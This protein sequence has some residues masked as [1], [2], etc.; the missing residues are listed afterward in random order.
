MTDT[1]TEAKQRL[2]E[3]L[4]YRYREIVEESDIAPEVADER[5][6]YLEKTKKNLDRL[7]F[8][9]NQQLPPA[10]VIPR[11][12][13][14]GEEIAPQI[15]PDSPRTEKRNGKISV[16]KYESKS[17]TPVRLSVHPRSVRVMR[18]RRYPLWVTE[19][20]K[21]ADSLVS[22]KA[23]A[24]ALQGVTCWNVPQDWEDVKLHGRDVIL[25]FDADQM[26][27]P[28]VQKELLKLS[29][30][31]RERGAKVRYLRWPERYKGTKTGVDD[32]LATGE[33]TIDELLR[34][35]DDAPDEEAIEVGT[36]LSEIEPERVEWLWPRRIPKGK[37][38]IIDGD[39][40]NG[41]SVLSTDLV[42]RITAGKP[43]PDGTPT[44][45]AG[46]I[47]LSAED[48]A[49]DTIRPRLDAAGGNPQKVLLLGVIPE[50]NDKERLFQIPQDLHILE[51]AIRQTGASIVVI[52]PLMAFLSSEVSS[53]SDQD[54]RR[55]LAPLA[56]LAERTG[57]AIVIIRHLNKS[58]GGNT[59]YRG[60]G[61]IGIIGAARSGLVVGKHPEDDSIRVLA[62]QKNNLSLPPDSLAYRIEE[63]ENGSARISYLGR[64]ETN[65]KQLLATP[66]DEE[67]RT[68]LSEAK[69][70]LRDRLRA[71]PEFASVIKKEF[72]EADIGSKRTL[73]RAKS[74]LKVDHF[75]DTNDPSGRWK[76]ILP[77]PSSEGDRFHVGHL[78][79]HGQHDNVANFGHYGQHENNKPTTA[80]E[81]LYIREGGQGGQGGQ[82]QDNDLLAN[83]TKQGGQGGQGGQDEKCKHEVVG[84]C[85]L[86]NKEAP[87]SDGLKAGEAATFQQLREI[88]KLVA[89]GMSEEIAREAVIREKDSAEECRHGTPKGQPCRNCDWDERH[90]HTTWIERNED[91]T[92][93]LVY[94]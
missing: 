51:R 26:I 63:A 67:D 29:E 77:E 7:G 89:E 13:P 71:G 49:A 92:E 75:R 33:A 73:R 6:Y 72:D 22:H 84:G 18:D 45:V 85:W 39:P 80:T 9:R 16:C 58:S 87:L 86:C 36:P 74:E 17:N 37:I 79:Q 31:L 44:E 81:S 57:V 42:A 2:R 64:T 43:L 68:A 4:D 23:V 78:G 12:S 83:M 55:A 15:K 21:K 66:V 8:S 20:D 93:A 11:F 48:G 62:G 41:K 46:G 19:G 76:W 70:F 69:S 1:T 27:N 82:R 94:E 30:F 34:W 25:A 61:S 50:G 28:N 38:T 53:N 40:D 90:G 88:R 65:A 47:I 56:K 3:R 32:V 10:I 60:G 91:G 59:L 24:L 52:D 14:S 5:G 54:V 35:T